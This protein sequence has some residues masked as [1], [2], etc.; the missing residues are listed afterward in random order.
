M[1]IQTVTKAIQK[2]MILK[3]CCTDSSIAVDHVAQNGAKTETKFMLFL[4]LM[5]N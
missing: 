2:L 1:T 4:V 3:Q 5:I